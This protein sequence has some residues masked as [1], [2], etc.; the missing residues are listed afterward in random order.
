MSNY[1]FESE[2]TRLSERI[3]IVTDKNDQFRNY[4]DHNSRKLNL[5]KNISWIIA[6]LIVAFEPQSKNNA[7]LFKEFIDKYNTERNE[8]FQYESI[9]EKG[10]VRLIFDSIEFP[11]QVHKFFRSIEKE[12]QIVLQ[13]ED[14]SLL[15]ML[16][17]FNMT[18]NQSDL[19]ITKDKILKVLTESELFILIE[20]G[21]I[22]PSPN[23]RFSIK[24]NDYFN[25]LRNEICASLWI[26]L[27]DSI[28]D[29]VQR[30]KAFINVIIQFNINWPDRLSDY[31]NNEELNLLQVDAM[32]ILL[33]EQDLINDGFE[34]KKLWL[35]SPMYSHIDLSQETPFEIISGETPFMLLSNISD[36]QKRYHWLYED[37][38]SVRIKYGLLLNIILQTVKYN[39]HS[40]GNIH[41]IFDIVDEI[42]RPYLVYHCCWIIKKYYQHLLPYF[43]IDLKTA[44]IP[45]FLINDIEIKENATNKKATDP[46]FDRKKENELKTEFFKSMFDLLLDKLASYVDFTEEGSEVI[47][48]LFRYQANLFYNNPSYTNQDNHI[49]ERSRFE[50]LVKAFSERLVAVHFTGATR[51]RIFSK[52][53]NNFIERLLNMPFQGDSNKY[54]G[55]NCPKFELN[56]QILSLSRSNFYESEMTSEDR[57]ILELN[58]IK[59]IEN[60]KNLYL[61]Y[62]TKDEIEIYDAETKEYKTQRI[63]RISYPSG[64]E[65][66]NWGHFW[67][68]INEAGALS[69]IFE[70]IDSSLFYDN[71][72]SKEYSDINLETNA[73]LKFGMKS[74]AL[75]LI[76]LNRDKAQF[77]YLFNG[78]DALI[79]DLESE[80]QKYTIQH[81][82]TD[83]ENQ[84]INVFE[85]LSTSENNNIYFEPT[86]K[87]V[88]SALNNAHDSSP[89]K[90]YESL[91]KN[92]F[93]LLFLLTIL[94][95]TDSEA[96]VQL[97]AKRIE[98]IDSR[99]YIDNVRHA[100]QWKNAIIESLNSSSHYE[101]AGPIISKFEAWMSRSSSI[102]DIYS[103]FIFRTKL[104]LAFKQKNLDELNQI[105]DTN[106]GYPSASPSD[107]LEEQRRYFIALHMGY[108]EDKYDDAINIFRDLLINNPSDTKIR[109]QIFHLET[110]ENMG[111]NNLNMLFRVKTEW[112]Q[113]FE[114]ASKEEKDKLKLI[115]SNVNYTLLFHYCLTSDYEN[116]DR[117][118]QS[119][120]SILKFDRKIIGLVFQ[121]YQQRDLTL[122][123]IAYLENVERHYN[124][125]DSQINN[126]VQNLR[127]SIDNSKRILDLGSAFNQIYSMQYKELPRVVPKSLNGKSNIQ[128]F[129]F[130]EIVQAS[131][132]LIEKINSINEIR[133]ENKYN[134]LLLA[135][136]KLRLAVW[137]WSIS[138][139]SRTGDSDSTGN[140]L[141]ELDFLITSA[142][143]SIALIEALI[144]TYANKSYTQ[145]HI[146][147]CFN[148]LRH[149]KLHYV[150]VY[151]KGPVGNFDSSWSSYKTNVCEI[152]YDGNRKLISKDFNDTSEQTDKIGIHTGITKHENGVHMYHIYLLILSTE[153]S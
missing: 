79:I 109:Y 52:Y 151:F 87:L 7:S 32:K 119:L 78:I 115:Q 8:G 126:L 29:D 36:L 47:Y 86:I 69:E 24:S 27:T 105:E 143:N 137:G 9:L 54:I 123:A 93:D 110:L 22:S 53:L 139:Q 132:I 104:M 12:E 17:Q 75:G 118:I 64:I 59:L 38:R 46:T 127:E 16:Y 112:D 39:Y 26:L 18:C 37:H 103:R 80:L 57:D 60:W 58:T 149:S 114:A 134:D 2:I 65:I 70:T 142:G 55:F 97:I 25:F 51:P 88:F 92:D 10:W 35:D 128:E 5:E 89:I 3:D 74:L 66:L 21:V 71:T 144:L 6:K 28:K 100:E 11:S 82:V 117:I 153:T 141:G 76:A 130:Q 116:A 73:K 62:F 96:V 94:N 107:D 41:V 136:L 34:F 61:H 42:K 49:E 30:L 108:N 99:N 140:D 13:E 45:F 19:S 4:F 14:E 44:S 152:E 91:L 146:K 1:L 85:E 81:C 43:L 102:R 138:D 111:T 120:P 131:L 72:E 23:G 40:K 50:Y 135:I 48:Q 77:T 31:L 133:L 90:F 129:I 67:A 148:Y 106:T 95:L 150:V 20:N 122:N 101:I 121:S 84:R 113:F 15:N 68:F 83:L 33:N 145:D 63:R 125:K 147:K 124:N 56:C 98:E